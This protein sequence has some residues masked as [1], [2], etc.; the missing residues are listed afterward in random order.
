M[1]TQYRELCKVEFKHAYYADGKLK[2]FN[3]NPSSE[4]RSKMVVE[5]RSSKLG[6]SKKFG[7]SVNFV[8]EENYLIFFLRKPLQSGR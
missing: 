7:S 4:T 3:L 6:V 5:F 1:N 2:E 8:E